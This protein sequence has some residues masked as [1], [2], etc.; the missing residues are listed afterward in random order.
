MFYWNFSA[1]LTVDGKKITVFDGWRLN[2]RP[3]DSWRVNP[4]ETLILTYTQPMRILQIE[5]TEVSSTIFNI[6][7]KISIDI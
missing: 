5:S 1:F 7:N 6:R 4:I 2:F 3:F